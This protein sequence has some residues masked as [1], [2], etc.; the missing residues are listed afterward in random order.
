SPALTERPR[1]LPAGLGQFARQPAGGDPGFVVS[2]GRV[3]LVD[4]VHRHLRPSPGPWPL[5]GRTVPALAT[6][7]GDLGEG[8]G[9]GGRG[10]AGA[11]VFRPGRSSSTRTSVTPARIRTP[12]KNWTSVGNSPSTSQANRIAKSTSV[13]PT[14]EASRAPRIRFAPMPAT[15]ATSAATSA[16]PTIGTSQLVVRPAKSTVWKVACSGAAPSRPSPSSTALPT[17]MPPPARTTDGRPASTRVETMKYPA[18]PAA[19]PSAQSTPSGCR[20]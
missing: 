10:G 20:R 1:L 11:I 17:A 3:S 2:G 12:P 16:N 7:R 5:F 4:Q 8:T 19:A 9:A 13:R 14:N 15:Y 6:A 18:R